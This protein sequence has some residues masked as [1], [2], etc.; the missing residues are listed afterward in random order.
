M[1]VPPPLVTPENQ[2]DWHSEAELMRQ[3][4]AG[5]I[6]GLETAVRS[7]SRDG[8]RACPADHHRDGAGGGCRPGL[9]PGRVAKR[10][11]VCRAQGQRQ[12]LA[13][14]HRPPPSHR[15]DAAPA[16]R[17]GSG[18]RIGR[19]PP[20][21]PHHARHLAR[22]GRPA[23]RGAGSPGAHRASAGPARSHR[24]GLLRRSDP[25]AR[26]R[27]KPTLRWGPSRAGCGS[28]SSPCANSSA[29][30]RTAWTTP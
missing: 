15:C 4:A 22:G 23:R 5:D 14:R 19:R 18:R 2:S 29:A 12:G 27:P 13:A 21:G 11:P 3:V 17:R 10:R 7:L 28:G 25:D 1:A 8:V 26:L 20:G 16:I 9:V 6:G 30:Q 24:A